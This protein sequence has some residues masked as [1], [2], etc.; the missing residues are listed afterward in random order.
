[1]L[2]RFGPVL[3]RIVGNQKFGGN[4]E[5]RQAADDLE[6]GQQHQRCDHAGEDDA[7]QDRDAGAQYHAP[8]PLPAWQAAAGHGNDHGV[9]AREQNVD[10]HDLDE[11]NPEQGAAHVIPAAAHHGEPRGRIQYLRE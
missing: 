11:G 2:D 10:P 5:Q 8:E 3:L 4:V 1:M 7:Q 6:I 9:V